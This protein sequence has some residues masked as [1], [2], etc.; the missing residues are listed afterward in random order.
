ELGRGARLSQETL[1]RGRL[2]GLVRGQE[3]DRH[4]AVEPQL[5]RKVDDPHAAATQATLQHVPPDFAPSFEQRTSRS[6]EDGRGGSQTST[7]LYRLLPSCIKFCPLCPIT[8]RM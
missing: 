1:A 8:N 5:A 2:A 4:P 3:L 6:V 7:D